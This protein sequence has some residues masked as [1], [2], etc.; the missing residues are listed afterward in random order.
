MGLEDGV[1]ECVCVPA[2]TR[3]CSKLVC[4][5]QEAR[6]RVRLISLSCQWEQRALLL[7]LWL[8]RA[9]GKRQHM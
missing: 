3:V 2:H 1:C 5:P 7:C 6:L 8:D 9:K 4:E